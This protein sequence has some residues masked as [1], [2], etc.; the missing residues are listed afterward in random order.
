MQFSYF[1]VIFM[2]KPMYKKQKV[3]IGAWGLRFLILNSK[4]EILA[5]A[6]NLIF[7]RKV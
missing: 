1:L 7:V 5:P 6:L 3:R 2:Q 4:S